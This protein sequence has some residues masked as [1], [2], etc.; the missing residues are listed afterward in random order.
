MAKFLCIIS[1]HADGSHTNNWIVY[2]DTFS[3]VVSN[4]KIKDSD[5][6]PLK[7]AIIQFY[8]NFN[9]ETLND[10]KIDNIQF[11][12]LD[13]DEMCIPNKPTSYMFEIESQNYVEYK[14]IEYDIASYAMGLY[15]QDMDY[16]D[17]T[18]EG[19]HYFKND[20]DIAYRL[21]S[22]SNVRQ[23]KASFTMKDGSKVNMT[24]Y[25]IHNA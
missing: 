24:C 14:V 25:K 8:D 6:Q 3:K 18:C 4:L 9:V 11:K 20:G 2:P 12:V 16:S 22:Y 19:N 23:S 10:V 21:T 13:D 1:D 17:C 15:V 5:I 7:D